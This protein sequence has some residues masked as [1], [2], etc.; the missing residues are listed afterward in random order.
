MVSIFAVFSIVTACNDDILKMNDPGSGSVEGFFNTADDFK[1]GVNGIYNS[2]TAAGYFT[3]FWGGNYFH[4]N[5]EFDV[6][7]DNM[8]GQ[9]ASWKGYSDVASGLLNPN[10]DGITAWK[11]SYGLGAISKVNQMLAVLPNVDFGSGG[12]EIWEAELKF[13]RGLCM[14]S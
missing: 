9:G 6:I 10:T 2:L 4:M 1:L 12:S 5:M 7:S 8:V 11:W 14:E 3:N 13:L